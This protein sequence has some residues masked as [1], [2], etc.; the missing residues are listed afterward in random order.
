MSETIETTI[1][2]LLRSRGL[3]LATAES[4]TGGLLGK[5]FTDLPGSSDYYWGGVITYSDQAKELLLGVKAQTLQQ[6]G[7]VSPETAR[8]MASGMCRRAGTEYALSITGVAGPEGGSP[9]KPV[10]LVYIALAHAS[11]CEVRELRLGPSRDYIRIL[12]AKSALD[13]LR[14]KILHS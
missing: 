10:G 12:S 3:K 8:E 1:G 2:N 7:A 11:G 13:L 9:E 6:Y 4:C 14:R 5:M